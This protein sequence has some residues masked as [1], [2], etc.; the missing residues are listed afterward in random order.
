MHAN[1]C[2]RCC[3]QSETPPLLLLQLLLLQLLLLRVLLLLLLLLLV[4]VLL[5]VEACR[6]AQQ[7]QQL[8]RQSLL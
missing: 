1:C 3:R 6:S 7:L 2:L 4:L 5:T 8:Y